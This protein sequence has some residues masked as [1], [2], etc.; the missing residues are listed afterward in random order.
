MLQMA[1]RMCNEYAWN[2]SIEQ[3]GAK[4]DYDRAVELV[5]QAAELNQENSMRSLLGLARLRQGDL[6]G[7]LEAMNRSLGNS[8]EDW[9][10]QWLIMAMAQLANGN[11]QA[12]KDWYV[13]ASDRIA[14]TNNSWAPNLRLQ[15][16]M[17]TKLG[18]DP[19]WPPQ[20]WSDEKCLESLDRLVASWPD[21]IN[22][23]YS[24]GFAN[25]RVKNWE[26]ARLDCERILEALCDRIEKAPENKSLLAERGNMYARLGQWDKA[27]EDL[28]ASFD[29]E[30]AESL[31]WLHVAPFFLMAG[32][33]AGYI[34]HCEKMLERFSESDVNGDIERTIKLALIVPGAIDLDRLPLDRLERA[35]KGDGIAA[36]KL[37]WGWACQGLVELRRGNPRDALYCVTR[38]TQEEDYATAPAE[39]ALCQMV[40]TLAL[41]N[42]GRMQEARQAYDQAVKLFDVTMSSEHDALIAELLGREADRNFDEMKVTEATDPSVMDD[43]IRTFAGRWVCDSIADEDIDGYT[44]KGDKFRVRITHTPFPDNSG[45][46]QEWELESGGVIRG[47]SHGIAIWDPAS[48]SIK[49]YGNATGGFHVATTYTKEDG[50]WVQSSV[51]TYPDGSQ[52]T[53]KATTSISDDGNTHTVQISDRIDPAGNELED[54]TD[55]WQRITQS[56][57]MLSKHAGWMIGEWGTPDQVSA[58]NV[59]WAADGNVM[60]FEWHN[61][62]VRGLS[63]I[64]WDASD[65]HIKMWGADSSGGNGQ[66]TATATEKQLDW[67]NAVFDSQGKKSVMN[68][69]FFPRDESGLG[70]RWKDA[71]TGEVHEL[72]MSRK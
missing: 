68:I 35:V 17:A 46:Q 58:C 27:L 66:A 2:K 61:A 34:A 3:Q 10:G 60:V 51:I 39:Q 57:E 63:I 28:Q 70:I 59:R 52:A 14:G 71:E 47:K 8:D 12:A 7:S 30:K 16:E 13:A 4:E 26:A 55:T 32:D 9:I 38:A 69:T 21:N 67:T 6:K 5:Q 64:V 11:Q 40:K 50:K 25:I 19:A 33:Q 44:K 15:A 31:V 43:F 41:Q 1:A 42:L 49:G 36:W 53:S 37:G 72:V 65:G 48:K 62:E 18:L 24:H 56:H 22:L 54:A 23:R 45:V 20:D 29:P